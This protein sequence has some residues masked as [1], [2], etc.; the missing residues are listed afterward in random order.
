MRCVLQE[1]QITDKR[2]LRVIPDYFINLIVPASMEEEDFEK[3]HTDFG[4][5]MKVI[6]HQKDDAVEII[7]GTKNRKIDRDTAEFLNVA[8]SLQLVYDEPEEEAEVDMCKAM[9][10][11]NKRM[12]IQGAIDAYRDVELDDQTIIEKLME[13]FDLSRS[14]AE[15]YVLPVAV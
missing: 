15:K 12:K 4:F 14:D 13:K 3:F 2:L 10:E 11:N 1:M 9:E 5:A 8:A 7:E 6:R